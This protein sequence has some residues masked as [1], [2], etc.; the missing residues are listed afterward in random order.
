MSFSNIIDTASQYIESYPKIT[1]VVLIVCILIIAY[2][3]ITNR[4]SSSKGASKPSQPNEGADKNIENLI[5]EIH[6]KQ[7][8]N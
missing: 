8:T 1:L 3:W 5:D 6:S 4:V 2:L 7:K